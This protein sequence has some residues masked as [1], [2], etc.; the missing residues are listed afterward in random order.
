[1]KK[2][3]LTGF[4][5][6]IGFAYAKHLANNGWHLDLV[7]QNKERSLSALEDLNYDHCSVHSCNLS[8][9]DELHNLMKEISTPDL[10][11]ANAGIGINGSVGKNSS[12]DIQDA[13][14]LM[15]GGVIGLIEYFLPK[16][17]E[18]D[19]GRVVIISSI[20][21]LIPMPKSSIYAA[22]KSGI[23]AYGRSLN[24]ELE[25]TNVSVTVSLPGYVRTN[26]HQRSG[27][28]H[29]TKKIPNWMWVSA[30]KVV[31]ETE[32]ASMKGKSHI[33]PGFLYRITS[34]FF[35]LKITKIIWKTLNA[36]K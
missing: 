24:E 15:F 4:S 12:R 6:G 16:M 11:I 29:L 3:L 5:S 33:I 13:T 19:A 34:I 17:K 18:K 1:M 25:N 20:G 26:I 9:S 14:Y 28:E 32:K 23:Y 30:D 8:S 10:L 7:S 21:A 27:L 22:V 31:T 35:N 2:A 36:R